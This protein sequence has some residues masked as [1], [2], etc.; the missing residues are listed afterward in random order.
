MVIQ[1]A[2]QAFHWT[3]TQATVHPFAIYLKDMSSESIQLGSFVIISDCLKHD[4]VTIHLFLRHLIRFLKSKC[5][6][7]K[8]VYFSDG[9]VTQYKNRKNFCNLIFHEADFGVAAE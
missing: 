1:D 2:V 9:A 7:K 6:V 8:I 3:N 5:D 4:C